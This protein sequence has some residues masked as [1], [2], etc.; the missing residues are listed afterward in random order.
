[1]SANL[2]EQWTG[3]F[4]MIKLNRLIQRFKNNNHLCDENFVIKWTNLSNL[5]SDNKNVVY[6]LN[7]SEEYN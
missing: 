2:K 5:S 4:I 6:K 3:K 7:S 1:M